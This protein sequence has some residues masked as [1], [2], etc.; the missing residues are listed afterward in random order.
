MILA[1]LTKNLPYAFMSS[2][3]ALT[4]VHTELESAARTLGAPAL[5]ALRDI[6]VPL[7]AGGILTGSIVVFANSLRELSAAALLYTSRTTVI[8]TAIMDLDYASN[9]GGVAAL[10]VILLAI[11]A[12]VVAVGYRLFGRNILN[13]QR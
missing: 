13:S 11:N 8:A 6:T 10:S 12:L 4:T 9:W 1:F 3:A 7:I 5:R 2:S